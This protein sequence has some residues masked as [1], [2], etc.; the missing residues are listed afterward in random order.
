LRALPG[1]QQVY[2]ANEIVAAAQSDA[3]ALRLQGSFMAERSGDLAIVATPYW[4]PQA[5]GTTH[6]SPHPYDRA[7]PL[8]LYGMGIES[9]R[10]L[11]SATPADIAPTL[12][13]LTGI[14]LAAADGR[15]LSEA[16][17]KTRSVA[18]GGTNR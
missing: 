18:P 14:Q 1:V 3:V 13:Y 2:W 11:G 7:V 17:V 5:T 12:A 8:V 15:V 6:G 9:G 10:Y 4:V 16:L